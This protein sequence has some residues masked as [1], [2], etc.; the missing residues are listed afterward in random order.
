MGGGLEQR[1]HTPLQNARHA[2]AR[3]SG[4]QGRSSR[5]I[6]VCIF[7]VFG[8]IDNH[9]RGHSILKRDETKIRTFSASVS[10]SSR[11]CLTSRGVEEG[12]R[13]RGGSR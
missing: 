10:A 1:G 7:F 9:S 11:V 6:S 2:S 5:S 3:E 4:A 12:G 8:S 13:E